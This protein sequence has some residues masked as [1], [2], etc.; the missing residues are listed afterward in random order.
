MI[1]TTT[2]PRRVSPGRRK[3][4]AFP[5]STIRKIIK[6]HSS[7]SVGSSADAL[8]RTVAPLLDRAASDAAF[9]D[10]S[11][12]PPLHPTVSFKPQS[13]LEIQPLIATDRL[14][15]NASKKARVSGEKRVN[16]RDIRK[17]TLVSKSISIQPEEC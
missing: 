6:A 15:L 13:Q 2:M 11:R 4:R 3:S 14:M 16:A 1:S 5:R 12:L 17:V 9:A 8:V 10:L 7:K